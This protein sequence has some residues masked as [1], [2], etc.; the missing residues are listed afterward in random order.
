MFLAAPSAVIPDRTYL[1]WCHLRITATA[2]G[3]V[4]IFFFHDE[5]HVQRR[6]MSMDDAW[7]GHA[8]AELV[9]YPVRVENFD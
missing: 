7:D 8:T 1:G 2:T 4:G 6:T 9:Y 3:H 5:A